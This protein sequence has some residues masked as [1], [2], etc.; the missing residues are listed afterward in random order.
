VAG[1]EIA[2]RQTGSGPG[3]V[4]VHGTGG[5]GAT[6]WAPLMRT[7]A[8]ART[9]VVPDLRGSGATRDDGQPLD[10]AVLAEDV[11][12]VAGAAG[13]DTFDLAGFSL[14][15]AVAAAVAAAAPDRVRALVLIA[16]T[17]SGLDSR[18]RLQFEFWRDLYER[19]ADLF[20][21]YW[22]LA[23]FSPAAVAAIAPAELDRAATFP[24]EPGLVRQ[25]MLNTR[26][27][28]GSRLGGIRARTLVIGCAHD[29]IVPA[30]RAAE[31]AQ[32]IPAAE[33]LELDTG[34]MVILESPQI[35]A[36][37]LVAH[38]TGAPQPPV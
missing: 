36:R 24:I 26:V 31:L 5:S 23:G 18:S 22:L 12:A 14:G 15:G 25:A 4:L 35:L 7:L 29:T 19:D 10:L 3:L 20:A 17:G 16:A 1:A 6:T 13:C 9:L 27:D 32:A 11:L 33:Y 37:A 38:F 8:E 28:L 34:H 30:A 21:R 2:Y